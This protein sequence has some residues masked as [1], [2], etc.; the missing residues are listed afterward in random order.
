MWATVELA[1]PGAKGS[2]IP[3]QDETTASRYALVLISWSTDVQLILEGQM[4]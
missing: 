3:N 2:C 1:V 4:L